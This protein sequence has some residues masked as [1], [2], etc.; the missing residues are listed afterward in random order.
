MEEYK[1]LQKIF[2]AF[3][4]RLK[5]ELKNGRRPDRKVRL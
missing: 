4:S 3:P 1:Y 2:E 5:R